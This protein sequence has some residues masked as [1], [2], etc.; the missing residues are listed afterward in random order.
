MQ[1]FGKVL[2]IG[3]AGLLVLVLLLFFV[4]MFVSQGRGNTSS[5]Q[6]GMM[7]G[8]S[9]LFQGGASDFGMMGNTVGRGVPDGVAVAPE[10]KMMIES[11]AFAP[12]GDGPVSAPEEKKVMKNGALNI[13]VQNADEASGRIGEIVSGF[14]GSVTDSNFSQGTN[15]VKRGSV[16][17][18]VP[19][20]KFEEAFEALKKVAT[21]VESESITGTDVTAQY[22]DL[23]ARLKNKKAQEEALQNI[24]N[25]AEKVS[26]IIDITNELGT[27]RGEIES[28]EGQIRYLDSQTDMASITIFIVEDPRV[29]GD[30]SFR[31]WQTLIGSLKTLLAGLGSLVTGIIAFA[32]VGVPMIVAYGLL[33]WGV[34]VGVRKLM[35]RLFD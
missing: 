25:R 27:V 30:R 3:L 33:L 24:L 20:A 26:D 34:F 22:I 29:T 4:R 1:K 9:G 13:R 10:Q 5:L 7:Q 32:I 16:T 11:E 8:R 12:S 14:G 18:K 6:N 15:N 2:L 31:P 35:K 19:V 28:L 23:S 17:V 21:L